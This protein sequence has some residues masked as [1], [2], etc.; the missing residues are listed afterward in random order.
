MIL[1]KRS[2]SGACVFLVVRFQSFSVRRL[3]DTFVGIFVCLLVPGLCV[4][5]C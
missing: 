4:V 2:K 5:G 1:E 3:S